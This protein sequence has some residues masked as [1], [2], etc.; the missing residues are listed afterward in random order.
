M[1]R[2]WELI[3]EYVELL[4]KDVYDEPVTVNHA[5]ISREAFQ[6]FVVP[7]KTSIG[8]LLDVGCGQGLMLQ[9]CRDAG[10]SA[11][12]V[13]LS[14]KDREACQ[15]KGFE[16][17]HGDQS[18]LEFADESFDVVW[19]RH[20]LEHS[21]MPLLTLFEYNR[22]LKTGGNCYVE[23]PQPDSLHVD[24]PNHYSLFS[25]RGWRSL[26]GRAQFSVAEYHVYNLSYRWPSGVAM[27]DYYYGYWLKKERHIRDVSRS[28]KDWRAPK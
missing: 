1:R 7:K 18:F 9:L 5:R 22:V 2:R 14:R 21:P 15:A 20:C 19:S 12:G 3:D 24:N 26:F 4:E 6:T 13:T 11:V 8:K 27:E 17:S 10:I 25:D 23:V 16:V 28:S